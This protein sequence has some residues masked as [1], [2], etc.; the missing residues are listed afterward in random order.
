MGARLRVGKQADGADVKPRRRL[1][2]PVEGEPQPITVVSA[3]GADVRGWR[4][5]FPA[6]R[7]PRA[8]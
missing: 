4:R 8:F 2:E 1:G 6:M 7:T 3:V 5:L